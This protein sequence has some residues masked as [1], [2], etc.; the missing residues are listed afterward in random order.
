M[1]LRV[2]EGKSI[3]QIILVLTGIFESILEI[4]LLSSI[5]LITLLFN[6]TDL[7]HD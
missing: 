6:I 3:L 4:K 7:H 5:G 1:S 2:I